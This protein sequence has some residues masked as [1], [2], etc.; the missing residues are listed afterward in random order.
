MMF[1]FLA[2][3]YISGLNTRRQKVYPIKLCHILSENQEKRSSLQ[4]R[5]VQTVAHKRYNVARE[6]NFS[7]C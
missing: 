6:E 7:E 1:S 2:F 3:N 5:V 4:F